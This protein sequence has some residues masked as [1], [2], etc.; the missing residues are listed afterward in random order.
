MSS[1]KKIETLSKEALCK[2]LLAAKINTFASGN[3]S[4]PP[5]NSGAK[6]YL[7]EMADF[8]YEDQYYGAYLDMGQ[9][10]VW[11]YGVPIWGMVYRGGIYKPYYDEAEEAFNFLKRALLK[12]EVHFPIRGPREYD[13]N[14]DYK[15]INNSEGNI[16][17]FSGKEIIL[18]NQK[19]TCFRSYIGGIIYGELNKDMKITD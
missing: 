12:P 14:T 17:S 9:E 11:Y 15:Y 1:G 7:Y 3:F 6:N 2:F 19:E 18:K 8:R 4:I 10:M 5:K 13:E 16:L